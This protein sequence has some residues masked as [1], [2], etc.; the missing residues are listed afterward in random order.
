LADGVIAVVGTPGTGKKTVAHHL[1][2]SLQIDYLDLNDVAVEK[3]AV[4][5]KE[6]STYVVSTSKLRKILL[7]IIKGR[8]L[9][10][11]GHLIPSVLKRNEVELVILLRCAPEILEVRLASRGYSEAKI[12]ENVA[13]EVLGVLVAES[14]NAFG[15]DRVSEH[16]TSYRSVEDTVAEILSVISGKVPLNRPRIDWLAQ[17]AEK[18]LLQKYF[19]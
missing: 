13:A 4:V 5:G 15:V 18:G 2:S 8:R 1:S 17:A 3:G 9:V 19:P 16:D 14:L 10:L 7:P 12:K 11:S 6:G